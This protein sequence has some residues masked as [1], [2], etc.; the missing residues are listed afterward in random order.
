MRIIMTS[1]ELVKYILTALMAISFVVLV[2]ILKVKTFLFN[3]KEKKEIYD[4]AKKLREQ[5]KNVK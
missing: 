4:N 5:K 3:K 1:D 2:I